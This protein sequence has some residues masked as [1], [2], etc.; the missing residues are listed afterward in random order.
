MLQYKC[1]QM[2]ILAATDLVR[3]GKIL[4]IWLGF[5]LILADLV[6]ILWRF[7]GGEKLGNEGRMW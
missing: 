4:T 3:I 2:L 7:W 5:C 1:K 6:T